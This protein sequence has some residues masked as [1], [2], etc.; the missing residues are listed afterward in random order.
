VLRD[1]RSGERALESLVPGLD[2]T[3]LDAELHGLLPSFDQPGGRVGTLDPARLRAWA[4]WE[5]RFGIVN[6]RPDLSAMFATGF[7]P[8]GQ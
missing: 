2:P 8:R 5:Q 1:P 6:R 4:R 3:L 7:V